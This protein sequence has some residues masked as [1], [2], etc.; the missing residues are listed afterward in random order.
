[1]NCEIAR[2]LMESNDPALA[3]HQRTCPSC[4]VGAN[5]RY[6]EAPPALEQRVHAAGTMLCDR[7]VFI[8]G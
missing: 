8:E 7:I 4:I 3:A 1:M 6:Y 2:R 5:A